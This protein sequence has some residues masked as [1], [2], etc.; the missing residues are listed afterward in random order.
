MIGQIGEFVLR[1]ALAEAASWPE[2]VRIAV[3]LS[4]IQFNDPN[5]VDTVAALLAEYEF[6]P[7]PPRAGDHRRRVPCRQR[8]RPTAPSLG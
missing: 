7:A 1:T 4:P 2:N 6:E 5:I 3:N 8:C